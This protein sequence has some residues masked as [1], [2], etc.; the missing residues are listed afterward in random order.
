MSDS[1]PRAGDISIDPSELAQFDRSAIACAPFTLGIFWAFMYTPLRTYA[2]PHLKWNCL[3]VCMAIFIIELRLPCQHSST[4]CQHLNFDLWIFHW[5]N[6][7]ICGK[8]IGYGYTNG[9]YSNAAI[10]HAPLALA[11]TV[12]ILEKGPTNTIIAWI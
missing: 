12:K 8:T 3:F 10:S 11:S 4:L 6:F 7:I 2:W 1:S 9:T 5:A